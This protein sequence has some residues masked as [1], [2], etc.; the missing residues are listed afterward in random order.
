LQ[1]KTLKTRYKAIMSNDISNAELTNTVTATAVANSNQALPSVALRQPQPN[2]IVDNPI[3]LCGIGTGF[4]GEA[5]VRVRDGNGQQIYR[6]F[7]QVGGTGLMKNFTA[8]LALDRVPATP[9]GTLEVF[10]FGEDGQPENIIARIPI[11][12]GEALVSNYQ[13]FNQHTV[14]RGETLSSIAQFYYGD[15]RVFT[16]IFNANKHILTNPDRLTTGIVLRIPIGFES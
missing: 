14:A 2:D 10:G 12:F 7:I 6:S 9:N 1:S 13:G 15:S 16:R 8:S 5:Q 4:E 11:V 3:L